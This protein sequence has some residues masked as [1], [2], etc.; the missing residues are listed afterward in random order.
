MSSCASYGG[1]LVL[2]RD[3][4]G[5]GRGQDCQAT[6]AVAAAEA[7]ATN[8]RA[9]VLRKQQVIQQQH[10]PEKLDL[11]LVW[12]H[13]SRVVAGGPGP[14]KPKAAGAEAAIDLALLDA[15]VPGLLTSDGGFNVDAGMAGRY[16]AAG[17]GAQDKLKND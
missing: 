16:A 12:A 6:A 4:G 14:A 10:Q 1:D 3:A 9:A 17:G 2:R 11:G 8:A 7:R 13:I 15:C 5:S